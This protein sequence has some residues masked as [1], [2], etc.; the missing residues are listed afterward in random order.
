[1]SYTISQIARIMHVTE[2]QVYTT[3]QEAGVMISD[4]SPIAEKELQSIRPVLFHLYQPK[5]TAIVPDRA[6][7]EKN[8]DM[9][10]RDGGQPDEDGIEC[11]EIEQ[12]VNN[13][14]IMIDTCSLMH[15]KCEK[16]IHDLLPALKKYH[17]KIIIPKKVIDELR[18]HQGCKDDIIKA[19]SAEKGLNLCRMLLESGCLSI[20]GGSNDNFADNV[21]FVHFTNYRYQYHMLLITQDRKLTH[22]ILQIN[23]LGS[24]EGYPVKVMRINYNGELVNSDDLVLE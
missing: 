17:Q 3:L 4:D 14:K 1:M 2:E 20:R 8:T 21:F 18:K 22:D 7:A 12:L 10:E 11:S 6:D 19:T 16:M 5:K 24:A 13:N 9:A 23:Q 15:E